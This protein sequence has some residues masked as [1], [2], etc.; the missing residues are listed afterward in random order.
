MVQTKTIGD[1]S[2]CPAAPLGRDRRER[3]A[4]R[5]ELQSFVSVP[6]PSGATKVEAKEMLQGLQDI[7]EIVAF[8][9]HCLSLTR[10]CS[11]FFNY[12]L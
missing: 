10:C 7:T 4:N 8:C 3:D 9:N 11:P 6:V 2:G 12:Y 1:V 5:A